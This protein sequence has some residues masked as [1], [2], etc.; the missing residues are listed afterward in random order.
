MAGHKLSA[1]VEEEIVF[2]EHLVVEC[3]T[4]S[5]RVEEYAT[6]TKH[7]ESAVQQI[8]RSLSQI[9]Q[10]AMMKNLG[11]VADYAG[12][13]GVQAS[14]GSQLQRTRTLREG[15]TNFKVMLER[16]MKATIAADLRVRAE[17]EKGFA[18]DRAERAAVQAAAPTKEGAS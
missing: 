13:L 14:R 10:R 3:G 6:A 9:R 12:M 2:M 15:V 17:A 4:I 8:T 11:A 7:L 5:R 1:K 16:V 18:A